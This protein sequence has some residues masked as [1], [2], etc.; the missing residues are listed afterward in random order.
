MLKKALQLYINEQAELSGD[1]M[2]LSGSEPHLRHKRQQLCVCSLISNE[3]V[4]RPGMCAS[5]SADV[6]PLE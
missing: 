3:R 6:P 1:A 4:V 2:K 5:G